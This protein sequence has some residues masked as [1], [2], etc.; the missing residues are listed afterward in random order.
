MFISVF[1]LVILESLFIIV[2]SQYYLGGIERSLL[3][4]A[5]TAAS[6]KS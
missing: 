4:D 5:S 6:K 1:V 3:S 2:V